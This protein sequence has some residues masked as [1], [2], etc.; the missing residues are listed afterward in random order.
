MVNLTYLVHVGCH[1]DHH[2]VAQAGAECSRA[3]TQWCIRDVEHG[4]C[5]RQR[6]G[7]R[8]WEGRTST[9][10]NG[11]NRYL[12]MDGSG[13]YR[14]VGADVSGRYWYVGTDATAGIVRRVRT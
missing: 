1:L 10:A 13:R 5:G 2:V 7:E 11:A 6:E 14:Y 12:G 8:G 4:P 9:D 3:Q